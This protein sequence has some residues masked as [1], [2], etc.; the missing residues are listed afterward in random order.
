MDLRRR[1]A[2]HVVCEIQGF[3]VALTKTGQ[4]PN[5]MKLSPNI[6]CI[7]VLRVSRHELR[8]LVRAMDGG[9]TAWD[10]AWSRPH[11][12]RMHATRVTITLDMITGYD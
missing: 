11:S 7:N 1:V 9:M 8:S 3:Q 12:A 10:L 4:E 5:G 6:R 2:S